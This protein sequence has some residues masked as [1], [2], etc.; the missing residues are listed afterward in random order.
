MGA[1]TTTCT[2]GKIKPPAGVAIAAA[3]LVVA[4]RRAWAVARRHQPLNDER[5]LRFQIEPP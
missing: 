3:I 2:C 4:P 5:S 1:G